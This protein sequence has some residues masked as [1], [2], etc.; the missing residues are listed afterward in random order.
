MSKDERVRALSN[1]DLERFVDRLVDLE[2][3]KQA[4]AQQIKE[5]LGEAEQAGFSKKAIRQVVKRKLETADQKAAREQVENDLDLMLAALG[6]L[7][8]TPLGEAALKRA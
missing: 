2:T 5:V 3:D 8:T 6:M 7:A 1:S 4:A